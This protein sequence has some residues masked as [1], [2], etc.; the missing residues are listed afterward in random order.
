MAILTKGATFADGDQVTSANLN[1]LVDAAAFVAGSGGTT[2]NAT[3]QVSG[4]VLAVKTIQT[5]N[6]ANSSVTSDKIG[7]GSVIEA[8]IGTGAVTAAKLATNSVTEAKIAANA[9]TNS[10]IANNAV[11]T[12][13]IVDGAV[14]AAKLDGAQTGS[15]PIYGV[16]AWVNFDGATSNDLTGTYSRTGG[17]TTATITITGHGLASGQYVYLDFASGTADGIYEVTVTNSSTFTITT[18]ETTAQS[19]V[20]VTLKRP[21]IL[22]SGNVSNMSQIGTG[23]YLVNFDEEMPDVNYIFWGSSVDNSSTNSGD[24]IISRPLNGVK[25]TKSI[26]ISVTNSGAS[27]VNTG[28]VGVAFLR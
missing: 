28:D 5:A 23:N 16:R 6:I 27:V 7:A 14:T 11:D 13:E 8:K 26:R 4:G 22:E 17:T 19:S 24:I 2:D 25:T 1:N 15:A 20:S 10:K 21:T 3:M 9:V 18:T 12:A